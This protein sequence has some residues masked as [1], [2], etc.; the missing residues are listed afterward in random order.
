MDPSRID[1]CDKVDLRALKVVVPFS[2]HEASPP[3]QVADQ[4]A[5]NPF[6]HFAFLDSYLKSPF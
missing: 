4:G 1:T 6:L 5:R 3:T 2:P